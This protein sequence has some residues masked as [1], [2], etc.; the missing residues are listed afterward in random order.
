MI[1]RKHNGSQIPDS[2]QFAWQGMNSIHGNFR[3]RRAQ[4]W[5]NVWRDINISLW[6]NWKFDES[7]VYNHV[8]KIKLA[9]CEDVVCVGTSNFWPYSRPRNYC[10]LLPSTRILNQIFWNL[11]VLWTRINKLSC[12][13][14][15]GE[16][17]DWVFCPASADPVPSTLFKKKNTTSE[18]RGS[19][20]WAEVKKTS[21]VSF[22][23]LNSVLN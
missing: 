17:S 22:L 10:Y 6:I 7:P 18:E 20:V 3:Y 2:P 5:L 12:S 21:I 23:L 13:V 19:Q 9:K 11:R 1:S 16:I 14:G 8:R 4:N 15:W